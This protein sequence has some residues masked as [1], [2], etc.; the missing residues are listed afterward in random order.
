MIDGQAYIVVA[1]R[2]FRSRVKSFGRDIFSRQYR[3]GVRLAEMFDASRM[4]SKP[5][6]IRKYYRES[7]AEKKNGPEISF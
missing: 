4:R 1:V 2:I 5:E 7:R 6:N 3:P